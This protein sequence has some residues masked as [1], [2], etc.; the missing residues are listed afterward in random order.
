MFQ[1]WDAECVFGGVSRAKRHLSAD[2]IVSSCPMEH[3]QRRAFAVEPRQSFPSLLD[4]RSFYISES[5]Y[6][7]KVW[8]VH[9]WK[10]LG[11][12]NI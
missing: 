1:L 6:V 7:C 5:W 10:G 3:L 4:R 9:D 12:L 2:P 11:E 8:I